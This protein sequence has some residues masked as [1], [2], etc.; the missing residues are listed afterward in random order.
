MTFPE[1]VTTV[2]GIGSLGLLLTIG[3]F[4]WRGARW[5]GSVDSDLGT[6]K[7]FMREIREDI[8]KI[9][10]RLPERVS[11]GQSPRRLTGFGRA[12]ALTIDAYKW[13][14]NEMDSVAVRHYRS[15]GF[16]G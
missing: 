1:W 5:S 15:T 10:S 9:F 8:K 3:A 13:V 14:E 16:C 2:V 12:I 7:D 4:L 6:L 11:V